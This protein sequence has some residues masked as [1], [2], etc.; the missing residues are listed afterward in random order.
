MAFNYADVSKKAKQ[1]VDNFGRNIT[2]VKFDEVVA[3]PTKPWDGAGDPRVTPESSI[4]LKGVFVP[5]SSSVEL[6]L[7]TIKPG[8]SDRA[9]QIIILAPGVAHK[10]V[11]FEQYDEVV[12]GTVR[13]KIV[14]AETLKP[15]SDRVAY[16][17]EVER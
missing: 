11:E 13:W 10:D 2:F 3:D 7:Q 17:V 9:R 5:P 8:F 14:Q 15:G 16:F 6:G 12:D 4:T 1:I